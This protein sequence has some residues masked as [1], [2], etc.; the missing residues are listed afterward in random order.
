MPAKLVQKHI[1][2]LK[3]HT[4]KSG[5]SVYF[6][7]LPDCSYKVNPALALGKRSICWRCGE[8]FILAEYSLRLAKP[9]CENCHKPKKEKDDIMPDKLPGEITDRPMSIPLNLQDRLK[10]VTQLQAI[11]EEDI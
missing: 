4:H 1:H 9:H 5:T 10:Q 3:R 2:K 6:C 7:T 8:S 11:E